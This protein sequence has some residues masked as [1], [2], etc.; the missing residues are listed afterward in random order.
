MATTVSAPSG[1]T[2]PLDWAAAIT[3]A[4]NDLGTSQIKIAAGVLRLTPVTHI[5]SPWS[6]YRSDGSLNGP[7]TVTFPVGLFSATP[8][9]LHSCNSQY[10]GRVLETEHSVSNTT[11]ATKDGC[12]LQVART[13]QTPTDVHWIAIGV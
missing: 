8:N 10:P 3:A 13:D 11:A 1:D 7:G 9:I 5:T 12:V 6:Y 2:A 4:V